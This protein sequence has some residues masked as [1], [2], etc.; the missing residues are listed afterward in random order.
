MYGNTKRG[1]LYLGDFKSQYDGIDRR[2][3]LWIGDS[4]LSGHY[5]PPTYCNIYNCSFNVVTYFAIA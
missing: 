1:A 3:G 5:L 2:G 4:I